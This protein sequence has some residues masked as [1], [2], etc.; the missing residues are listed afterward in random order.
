MT[1][2]H[3][4]IMT[5]NQLN[6][7]GQPSGNATERI[8]NNTNL[9]IHSIKDGGRKKNYRSPSTKYFNSKSSNVCATPLAG[10]SRN[11]SLNY[12]RTVTITGSNHIAANTISSF[13][14]NGSGISGSPP[15]F[16]HF[17]G[18]KC[19]D[20]PAP[21]ALPKPPFEW[22]RNF[23]SCATETSHKSKRYDTYSQNLKMILNV[24]A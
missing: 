10:K 6:A 21:T 1:N 7:K 11:E 22:V 3:N 23:K 17:A 20:A 2:S 18:S 4:K 13:P 15:N 14:T 12:S 19:Y 9:P 8:F 5:G 16:S 24:Q